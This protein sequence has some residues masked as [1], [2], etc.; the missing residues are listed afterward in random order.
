MA[1][2][3]KPA[4][5]D[6]QA[7]TRSDIPAIMLVERTEGYARLVGRWDAERHAC[8]MEN[9][10]S[11]YLLARRGTELAGFAILEG[12]GSANQCI[13]LR[14]IAVQDAGRGVGSRLLRSV[15]N[16]CFDDLAAH[17]VELLVFPENDRAHRVYL[18]TGFVEEGVVR[19][20]HRNDD[21]SFRSM[22]LMS[23]LRPE[24]AARR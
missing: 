2:N 8:E 1:P 23:L 7:A 12:V 16:V 11:R 14:R 19:D 22:R 6:L 18:K 4:I 20:L 10:S 9:P 15:L 3:L 13:R 17:R 24:W 5:M 21:G